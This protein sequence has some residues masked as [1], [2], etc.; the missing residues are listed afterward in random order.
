M[1]RARVQPR[2]DVE[3]VLAR[4]GPLHRSAE[5]RAWFLGL[6]RG[7]RALITHQCR[8][9]QPRSVMDYRRRVRMTVTLKADV[10][11]MRSQ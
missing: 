7:M 9:A 4:N 3:H 2:D 8:C 10:S 11:E 5:G 6:G 1:R